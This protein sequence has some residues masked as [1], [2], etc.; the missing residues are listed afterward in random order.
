M[1]KKIT[2]KHISLPLDVSIDR[3]VV[4]PHSILIEVKPNLKNILCSSGWI[5]VCHF[6]IFINIRSYQSSV[7]TSIS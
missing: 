3:V 1:A 5:D 7:F 4:Y 6:Y 2:N